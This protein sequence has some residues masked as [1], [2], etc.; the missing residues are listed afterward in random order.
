MKRGAKQLLKLGKHPQIPTF[1]AYFE[2]D[3]NLYLVEE[4]ITGKNL[5]QELEAEGEFSGKKN[6]EKTKRPYP[7]IRDSRVNRTAPF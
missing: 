2:E 4:L 5:L 6:L 3:E 7:T 1:Y